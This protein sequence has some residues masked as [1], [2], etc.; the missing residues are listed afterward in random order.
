[1]A[2]T[3]VDACGREEDDLMKF[4][5]RHQKVE[6]SNFERGERGCRFLGFLRLHDHLG[7]RLVDDIRNGQTG[8]MLS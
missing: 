3:Y 8:T 6:Q 4:Q 2:A 5:N 1:M 7:K